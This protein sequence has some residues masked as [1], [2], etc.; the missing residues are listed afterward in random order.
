[1]TFQ[2]AKKIMEQQLACANCE[3]AGLRCGVCE[4]GPSDEEWVEALRMAVVALQR[5]IP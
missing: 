5:V 4:D 1:M 2:E 3:N